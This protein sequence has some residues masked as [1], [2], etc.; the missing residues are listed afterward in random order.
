MI[1]V[2]VH[3]YEGGQTDL[4]FQTLPED[5]TAELALMFQKPRIPQCCYV[6]EKGYHIGRYN[7]YREPTGELKAVWR[8]L[9]T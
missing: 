3:L 1:R 4:C 7:V 9:H 5:L 2:Q 6:F 8:P